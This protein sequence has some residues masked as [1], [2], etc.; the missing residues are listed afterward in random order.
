[1]HQMNIFG[2]KIIVFGG[3]FRQ[4]LLVI[5]RGIRPD[6]VYSIKSAS[7]ICDHC[8]VLRLLMNMLL[9]TSSTSSLIEEI[10]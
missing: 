8:K 3:D 2:E 4:V 10:K 6:I 5:S 1:M 7:Y 9:Q